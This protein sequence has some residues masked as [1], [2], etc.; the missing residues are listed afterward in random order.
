MTRADPG[1][2]GPVLHTGC[3]AT[4]L[5][6]AAKRIGYGRKLPP[7]HGIGVAVHFVFGGYAAYAMEVSLENGRPHIH[8]CVCAVDVGRVVNPLGV[9]AQMI[10]A[11]LDGIS[12]A[13]H[14]EITV[15]DGRVQQQNFPDYPLLSMADAPDV[16]VDILR[17][18]YRPSG[19]G[20]MGIPTAAPALVNA[21]SAATAKRIRRLPIGV[22]L[23]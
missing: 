13:I 10:R 1:N 2:G 22:Q 17:T 14:L 6:Q 3:M 11:T 16:E 9:E 19:A 5:K 20:E 12:A 18:G 21:I 23:S 4:F 8:R 7:G 15:R